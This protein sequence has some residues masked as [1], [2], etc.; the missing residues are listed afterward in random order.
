M[1]ASENTRIG[2]DIYSMNNLLIRLMWKNVRDAGLD[3]PVMHAVVI[4]FL[5]T[6]PETYQKDLEAAFQV[7]RSTITKII[8]AMERRG[9]IRRESVSKDA[10]LKR[11]FLT[12]Q[13]MAL[14]QIVAETIQ[15]TDAQLM[16][17]MTPA[18][19]ETLRRTL[20]DSLD[21]LSLQLSLSP[22]AAAE[23]SF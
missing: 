9:Y 13:G 11:V 6:H 12:E 7:N 20:Q 4:E 21:K 19:G 2:L 17:T 10:R 8:Q 3:M 23:E 14:H 16:S 1:S 22:N 18:Q 5:V 15:M